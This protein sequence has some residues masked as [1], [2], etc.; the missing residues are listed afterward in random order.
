MTLL[1]KDANNFWQYSLY[2]IYFYCLFDYLKYSL[3]FMEFVHN[4][5]GL[6]MIPPVIEAK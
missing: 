1:V 5:F 2:L 3:A 6:H 4:S